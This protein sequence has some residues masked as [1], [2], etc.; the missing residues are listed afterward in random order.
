MGDFLLNN[1]LGI[2]ASLGA[3]GATGVVQLE[4][5]FVV[6]AEG[7]EGAGEKEMNV[8]LD[9]TAALAR[10][11]ALAPRLRVGYGGR[12]G[13]LSAATGYALRASEK[14][15]VV[16]QAHGFSGGVQFDI[17]P[18][19]AIKRSSWNIAFGYDV[20]VDGDATAT[21]AAWAGLTFHLD[22]FWNPKRYQE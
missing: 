7:D 19:M 8:G 2:G 4:P 12:W 20:G 10:D 16:K 5:R 11:I 9:L 1:G 6:W 18:L 22:A 15:G 3:G 21:H 17:N 13:E 14:D